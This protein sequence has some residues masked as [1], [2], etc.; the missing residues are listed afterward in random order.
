VRAVVKVFVALY[1]KGYIYKDHYIVN[2]CPRC[3]TAISDL[4]VEYVEEAGHLYHVRYDLVGGGSVTIATTRPE[5]MLGDTAVAVNPGDE[6]Y[7]DVVGRKA[8]L[9]LLGRELP[10]IADERVDPA[11]GTGALKITPAHD[12]TD[13]D[14]G[15]DHKLSTIQAI[16]PDGHITDEGG[17]YAGLS[18]A[19]ARERVI[20]DLRSERALERVEDYTHSVATCQRCGTHIEPLISLQWFMRMDELKRP[21]TDA[22]RDGRVRFTPERWGR[23]YVD[24]ME[25]LRPWCISRQLWWGHQLPVWY[26]ENEGCRETI[27]AETAPTECPVCGG[28]ALRRETDVLDTWFSSA[29]WPFATWGWPDQTPDLEYFY[30]TDLLSTAREIIFLW[31]ARMVMMGLEFVD[32]VPFREVYIHSVIQAPDGRRMSKSLGTGID[33]LEM[34][35]KYGADA[36]RFGLLLMSSSQDVRFS[37]EKIAMGRNFANKLWNAGRLVL[38]AADGAAPAKSDADQVDR[39][40]ASRLARAT[41]AV[42]EAL[43]RFAFSEAVDVLYHFVWDE[44]CDW[45]LELVKPRLYSDDPAV[46]SAAAGHAMFV[47]DGVVRL[48]HPFLPFVTEE[49]ASHYGAAPLLDAS[50]AVAGDDDLRPA[51]ED[52]LGQVQAAIQA[53]RTYRAEH[54]I[55]P[56][57]VLTAFFVADDGSRAAELYGSFAPAF[58]SLARVALAD[59]AGGGG[60]ETMVLVPGGRFEVAAPQVDRSD[61]LARL[62]SQLEKL[63]GEVRRS[64]AKLANTG[65]VSRAPESVVEKER[66][67]LAGYIADRDELRVRLESLA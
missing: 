17:P 64:E 60:D 48:L 28:G 27:V 21:A 25:N 49:I 39:W 58:R 38:L 63:E 3:G 1:A 56:A 45:Y 36:S 66:A 42:R 52:D 37:E 53:L 9:P 57:D 40:I 15:R 2:W 5:T 59:T 12:L 20:G 50:Y 65:F 31:V 8:I 26:C 13:F 43:D 67:K 34:I 29:L 7:R 47:L 30:P 10:V 18:I 46:R 19:D 55:A 22:V 44:V 4:E 6:R 33:P 16:G 51:D 32:D 11:F 23:V 41:A 14:I 54:R 62:R 61:E 24:W 35:A